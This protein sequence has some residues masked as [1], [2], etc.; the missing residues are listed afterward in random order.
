MD[1]YLEESVLLN[2]RII[3]KIRK[4]VWDRMDLSEINTIIP[5]TY[6]GVASSLNLSP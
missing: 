6:R 2:E 5:P 3:K 4:S 1:G